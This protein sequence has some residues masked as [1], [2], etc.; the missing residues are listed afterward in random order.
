M[1]DRG[2]KN[3][4]SDIEWSRMEWDQA[5]IHFVLPEIT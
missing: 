4:I 2:E 5:V 1:V 3:G